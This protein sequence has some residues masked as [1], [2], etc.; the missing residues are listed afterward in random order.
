MRNRTIRDKTIKKMRVI[1]IN[2]IHLPDRISKTIQGITME[3]AG[4][5]DRIQKLKSP[6]LPLPDK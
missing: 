5:M 6:L 4:A 1:P 3:M 2:P